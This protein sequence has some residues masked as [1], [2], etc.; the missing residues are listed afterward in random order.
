MQEPIKVPI[1]KL[2][3]FQISDGTV[4]IPDELL[5]APT[6]IQDY[7][8]KWV[9]MS[10]VLKNNTRRYFQF[11]NKHSG[12]LEQVDCMGLVGTA[13]KKARAKGISEEDV[14]NLLAVEKEMEAL[15]K[16]KTRYK[17]KWMAYVRPRLGKDVFDWR[18]GEIADMFAKFMTAE[19]VRK[20]LEDMGYVAKLDDV[21][22]FFL[23]NKDIIDKKRLE[24]VRSAKDYFLATDAGRMETLA[25]L[26]SR[27]IELFNDSY[28]ATKR[29]NIELRVLSQ[30][31]RAIVEQARKE[32]KGEELRL[33]VDGKI[34]INA[35]LQASATIQD[36]SKKLPI[37]IIPIYLV[38]V[39][40]GINPNRILTSLVGSFY[41][42]F[43][44]FN[45][46]NNSQ[47]PPSTIDLIRN[48]DWTAIQQY[49]EGKKQEQ[50]VEEAVY[51]E[52]T[53]VE[54]QKVKSKREKLLEMI[55][56]N[57][58]RKSDDNQ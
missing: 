25:M 4:V 40:Q 5:D 27:F 56:N 28:Y 47:S 6:D 24:F 13:L 18:R 51:E 37:N 31:I 55:K 46:F 41:K 2:E 1:E 26:H 49:H 17:M 16:Q 30:E 38:A 22:K 29:N 23:N 39:K 53:F 57:S 58:E 21:Y 34:D 12:E 15:K 7:Y 11:I 19:E 3:E 33:T 43:N 32:V 20:K 48:Y 44:G 45:R 35:S 50:V 36:I 10:D 8:V 42:D 52:L 54:Q 14:K 9:E